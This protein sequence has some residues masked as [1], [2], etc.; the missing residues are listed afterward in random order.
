MQVQVMVWCI[1]KPG[2]SI[3]LDQVREERCARKA[4]KA[5]ADGQTGISPIF[6][7]PYLGIGP[8]VRGRRTDNLIHL[9]FAWYIS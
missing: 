7:T 9:N 3:R 5:A 4:T 8:T 6:S 2:Y 1:A